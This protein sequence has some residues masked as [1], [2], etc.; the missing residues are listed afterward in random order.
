MG[1]FGILA[2]FALLSLALTLWQWLEARRF[3]LHRRR[4]TG[5]VAPPLTVFKPL[6]GKDEWTEA[7]LRSWLEQDY[8][9]PAQVL[10]GVAS[11]EDPVCPIVLDLLQRHP[12]A[13][14][15]LVV[16][17]AALGANAKVS[18][19]AQLQPRARHE[20][21]VVSD[22]DVRV[23]KDFLAQLV[24]PL[25]DPRVGLVNPF[26]RL[27]NPS[28]LAM[29]WETV[30]VNADFWSSVLQAARLGPVSFA[31]GAVMAFR[32]QDLEALGGF[33]AVVN[34]LADDYELGRRISVL[35]RRVELIPV[36]V[37]C[38][39][40]PQG[41]PGVWRHQVRWARTIRVC[42]PGPYAAS[43]LSNA[44]FWP[45]LWLAACPALGSALGAG[46]CLLARLL[47]AADNQR[48]LN[49]SSRHLW[50][51]WIVPVKDLLQV[52]L[53]AASF[54]GSRVRW[55]GQ[56]YRIRSDGHLESVGP[57]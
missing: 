6:K 49:K 41:W 30:A 16:C 44:T 47:S 18:T 36:V 25:S 19:L 40:A 54:L 15:E 7:C 32:R 20:L 3:P 48:R 5:S 53:W 46:L 9:G 26:Y 43:V 34:H 42:R 12:E 13:Q 52:I 35:G 56:H 39:E 33:L 28:T 14:A 45:A 37:D 4:A 51:L 2:C 8:P 24:A 23:P 50:Y 27:A 31:L 21:W 10:F 1:A 55:R 22:A 38:C 17:P 29:R 11:T 57:E